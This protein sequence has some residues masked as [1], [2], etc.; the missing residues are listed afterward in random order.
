MDYFGFSTVATFSLVLLS[1]LSQKKLLIAICWMFVLV[2]VFLTY[3]Y[4]ASNIYTGQGITE[5]TIF[6]I[7]YG[8]NGAP[9]A[10][11]LWIL[12]GAVV[13][14][15]LVFGL[16]YS[17]SLLR[18]PGWPSFNVA[19]LLLILISGYFSIAAHPSTYQ[20]LV[21]YEGLRAETYSQY[22]HEEVRRD[23]Y[24]NT[25]GV[26]KSL[27]YV[28]L[29]SFE[30]T[31]FR[32]EVFPELVTSLKDVTK[33]S[34]DFSSIRQSPLTQWTMA[35]LAASQCGIPLASVRLNRTESNISKFLIP[36]G[37]CIS[38]ILSRE[39]YSVSYMGGADS[40]FSS[41][42]VFFQHH[43]FNN[44]YGLSY[45][46]ELYP[47]VETSGWG[48][49]DDLLF[50]EAL[51]K[52]DEELDSGKPFAFFM[53]TLDTHSPN[54][55]ETPSCMDKDNYG[56]GSNPMLNSIKCS[57]RLVSD[58]LKKLQKRIEDYQRDDIVIVVSSDHLQMQSTA[59]KTLL[60]VQDERRNL[61]FVIGSDMGPRVIH[62]EGTTMDIS[63]TVLSLL[64]WDVTS[65]GLGRNLLSDEVT[66]VE[67]YGV[68]S[69]YEM[70]LGWQ[71]YLWKNSLQSNGDG[72]AN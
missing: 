14:F 57:D 25:S 4:F 29:E 45:F 19:L 68:D 42:D 16:A 61:F 52:I 59:L 54:G 51:V 1:F 58:F 63:P 38:D 70:V 48:V 47:D 71:G 35:G 37:V 22:L 3:F 72:A 6:H 43:G 67:K 12:L 15:L 34:L 27:I 13:C 36:G 23:D 10:H 18:R 33:R 26:K 46:K 65:L 49:Y 32:E 8:V 7:L 21:I 5:A 20:L 55:H 62:R 50:G 30:R 53:L 64:G 11:V 31:F 56:S 66:L 17:V 41:K 39:G 2:S 40:A 44:V 24:T 69:F 28:Y 60:E 9:F